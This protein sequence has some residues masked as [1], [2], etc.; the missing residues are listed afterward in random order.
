MNAPA[1][2]SPVGFSCFV[3]CCL[4]L[5]FQNPFRAFQRE[6]TH[7]SCD[8]CVSL[9]SSTAHFKK[10]IRIGI[11]NRPAPDK[12]ILLN[13]L[14]YFTQIFYQDM[15]FVRRFCQVALTWTLGK[16]QQMG[17]R[18]QKFRLAYVHA[19]LDPNFYRVNQNKRISVESAHLP[20]G[21]PF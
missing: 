10:E 1:S 3:V 21:L 13:L 8:G 6:I 12:S 5:F 16:P 7:S 15:T 20:P 9:W 19:P 14:I 17:C 4:L 11:C 18:L 2:L